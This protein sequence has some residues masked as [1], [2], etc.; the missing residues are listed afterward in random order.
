MKKRLFILAALVLI[1]VA[2]GAWWFAARH[3]TSESGDRPRPAVA[4]GRGT[5]GRQSRYMSAFR[6]PPAAENPRSGPGPDDTGGRNKQTAPN[7]PRS[8]DI[9]EI[10]PLY[11]DRPVQGGNF[12]APHFPL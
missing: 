3:R 11:P 10:S 1:A 2:G 5:Q 8:T 7:G 9:H 6:R 4:E 12:S